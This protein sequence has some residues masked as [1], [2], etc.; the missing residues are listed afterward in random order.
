MAE[1]FVLPSVRTV[2]SLE[3]QGPLIRENDDRNP[4]NAADVLM[5]RVHL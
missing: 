3:C 1:G 5:G 4:R 2:E